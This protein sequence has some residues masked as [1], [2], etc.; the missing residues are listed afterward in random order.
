MRY[1]GTINETKGSKMLMHEYKAGTKIKT[2]YGSMK[3]KSKKEAWE[4]YDAI[5]SW[6]EFKTRPEG[7]RA[8]PLGL[9]AAV[10]YHLAYVTGGFAE[11]EKVYKATMASWHAWD[12]ARKI[13]DEQRREAVSMRYAIAYLAPKDSALYREHHDMSYPGYKWG[14]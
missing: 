10:E 12:A 2:P 6:G 5:R 4:F 3:F 9:T 14:Y 1:N 13:S 8:Q 7:W 11:V